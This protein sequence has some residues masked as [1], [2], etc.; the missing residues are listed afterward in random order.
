ML[1]LILFNFQ[2]IIIFNYSSHLSK[3]IWPTQFWHDSI[4]FPIMLFLC[5]YYQ[6]QFYV[7]SHF[8]LFYFQLIIDYTPNISHS[9]VLTWFWT[10]FNFISSFLYFILN[11]LFLLTLL[12]LNLFYFLF[13]FIFPAHLMLLDFNFNYVIAHQLQLTAVSGTKEIP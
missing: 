2:L 9:P 5:Y 6:S 13:H 7:I 11:V 8:I 10:I 4:W 1:F 3:H 12:I